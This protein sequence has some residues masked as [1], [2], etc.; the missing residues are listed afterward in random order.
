M[1]KNR[2]MVIFVFVICACFIGFQQ[3]EIFQLRATVNSIKRQVESIDTSE[4][5]NLKYDI[6]SNKSELDELKG[7]VDS[8]ETA[9]NDTEL[10]VT[11][12]NTDLETL[13]R[14]V[15]NI[16]DYLSN[17]SMSNSYQDP[18]FLYIP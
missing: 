7:S 8:L 14:K 5:S 15:D 13:E 1:N 18:S 9:S 17:L 4:I 6:E 3:Y 10:N 16:D 12:M 2:N 11:N